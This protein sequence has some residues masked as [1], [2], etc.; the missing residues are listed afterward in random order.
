MGRSNSGPDPMTR[1]EML[2]KAGMVTREDMELV[3]DNAEEIERKSSRGP[4]AAVLGD[5][6]MLV[7]LVR[8]FIS[9]RYRTI[10][11]WIAGAAAVALLYVLNPFDV[12][13]DVIPFLGYVDDAFVIGLC[14]GMV[15]KDLRKYAAWKESPGRA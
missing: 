6:K 3:L 12:V 15:R 9:G 1:E 8:D 14:L 13:P 7:S 11:R 5:V 2:E 4:L 10:P